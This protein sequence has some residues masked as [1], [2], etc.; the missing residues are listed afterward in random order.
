MLIS[1]AI[2]SCQSNRLT[3]LYLLVLER[4]FH[5]LSD[6]GSSFDFSN[7]W[8]LSI[9]DVKI[10]LPCLNYNKRHC[11]GCEPAFNLKPK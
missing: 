4:R 8:I 11:F 9:V 6:P 1:N 3:P 2:D 10:A 7:Q 5:D